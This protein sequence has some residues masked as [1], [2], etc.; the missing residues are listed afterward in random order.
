MVVDNGRASGVLQFGCVT[1]IRA[2]TGNSNCVLFLYVDVV[3]AILLVGAVV[4]TKSAGSDSFRVNQYHV[5]LCHS[6]FL[7]H[8]RL[9]RSCQVHCSASGF[10][11]P[12]GHSTRR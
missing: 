12:W 5:R 9:H 8:H 6:L 11:M 7:T 3:H 1:I 10:S 4:T 2:S